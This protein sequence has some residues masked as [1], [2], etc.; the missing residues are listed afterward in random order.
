MKLKQIGS[1]QTELDLGFAQVFFSYETPV[2]ARLAD[3]S[4]V[5]TD[6][7][8]SATTSKHIN[9][10]LQGCDALTVSQYRIDCLLTSASE[11]D[12]NYDEVA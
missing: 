10:W 4:L 2:A 3:G 1:N 11:C 5:R 8:Y 6:Q 7:W 12:S 9:K